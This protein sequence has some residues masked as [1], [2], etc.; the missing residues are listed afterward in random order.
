MTVTQRV[1]RKTPWAEFSMDYFTIEVK[2]ED[3]PESLRAE[4]D[5]K[6]LWRAMMFVAQRE[7]INWQIQQ[8]YMSIEVGVQHI[9]HLR[10]C[11]GEDLGQKLVDNGL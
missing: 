8:G 11:L 2:T 7:C 10:R 6:S 1:S 5:T 4:L 3:I 9:D